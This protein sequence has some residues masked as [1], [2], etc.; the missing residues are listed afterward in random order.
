S[1]ASASLSVGETAAVCPPFAVGEVIMLASV[2]DVGVNR[3]PG[4]GIRLGPLVA[5]RA[6]EVASAVISSQQRWQYLAFAAIT[7]QTFT[8]I[9]HWGHPNETN[10]FVPVALPAATG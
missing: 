10:G 4:A 3:S 6:G 5:G 2:S 9:E 8:R 1:S 7:V